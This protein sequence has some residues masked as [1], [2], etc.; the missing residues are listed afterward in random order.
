MGILASYDG[1][2]DAQEAI[3]HAARRDSCSHRLGPDP[4][5]PYAHG[6]HG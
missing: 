3:D 5:N 1:S 6:R 2:V 4:D